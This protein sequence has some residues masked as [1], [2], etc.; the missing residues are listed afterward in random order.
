[1]SVP[2]T[3]RAKNFI[4][5]YGPMS[6]LILTVILVHALPWYRLSNSLDEEYILT[7]NGVG[8]HGQSWFTV[9]DG[10]NF[11]AVSGFRIG[12]IATGLLLLGVLAEA[13]R[14]RRPEAT[15]WVMVGSGVAL[16]LLTASTA[17]FRNTVIGASPETIS[18]DGVTT[19]YSMSS[20][21]WFT[22]LAGLV[23]IIAGVVRGFRSSK[24]VPRPAPAPGAMPYPGQTPWSTEGSAAPPQTFGQPFP[25]QQPRPW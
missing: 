22:L 6:L 4:V 21:F 8:V 23:I 16:L 9:S 24:T 1:M 14:S 3:T 20:G 5:N 18:P 10:F 2:F 7:V 13:L 19:E 25:P 17:V 15:N 11:F 12:W